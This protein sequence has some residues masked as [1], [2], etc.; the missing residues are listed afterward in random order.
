[1][2]FESLQSNN[3][4]S[5]NSAKSPHNGFECEDGIGRLVRLAE[6]GLP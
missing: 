6:I 3:K 2:L 5:K 1:M 4:H